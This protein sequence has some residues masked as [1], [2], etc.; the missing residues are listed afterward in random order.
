MEIPDNVSMAA[1]G[2][3][4]AAG[5]AIKSARTTVLMTGAE[6]VAAMQKASSVSYAPKK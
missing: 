2:I 4:V 6:G 3:A 1:V 5:G